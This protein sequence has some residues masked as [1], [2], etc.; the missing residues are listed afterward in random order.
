MEEENK[1]KGIIEMLDN[2]VDDTEKILNI[3]RDLR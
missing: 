3:L 1:V 2:N